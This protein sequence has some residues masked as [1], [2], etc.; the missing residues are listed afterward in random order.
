M[1]MAKVERI[2][3]IDWLKGIA[4]LWL[5]VY[6]FH[7]IDWLRSPVPVFFFLSGLFFSDKLPF[8]F[9]LTKKAKALLIPFLFFFTLWLIVSYAG[10]FVTGQKFVFPE[11]WKLGT[12][13]PSNADVTNPLGAGAIWFL[14][15]LFEIYVIYYVIRLVSQKAWWIMLL[16]IVGYVIAI[17]LLQ[18]YANGSLFYLIYSFTFFAFF[19][20]AHLYREKVIFDS[21]PK[22][23]LIVS[24]LG[25]SLTFICG[26]EGG[27]YLLR[28]KGLVSTF[29]L[30]FL[31]IWISKQV[32]SSKLH[33][34][35]FLYRF[36]LFE[37]KNSLTILGVHMLAQ[38]FV[39]VILKRFMTVEFGYFI[40]LFLV[41]LAICNLCVLLFNR[42]VP[43]LVNHHK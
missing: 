2:D 9:F 17:L 7:A 11:P 16:N 31:L 14:I 41:E 23:L 42:Y 43:F 18:R 20:I 22:W 21:M 32:E 8:G 37:G 36:L 38:S 15:S 13:I 26:G 24:A 28:A 19:S 27:Y 34:G 1:I 29:G 40:V 6:H 33:D 3:W 30:I 39:G 35:S 4:I 12:L 10:M 25:Y 5:M